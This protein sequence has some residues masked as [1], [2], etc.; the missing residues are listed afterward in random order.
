[1]LR[2]AN[3]KRNTVV[4]TAKLSSFLAIINSWSRV[5]HMAF[6]AKCQSNYDILLASLRTHITFN[7]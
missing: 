6:I 5:F 1:M 3:D 4:S 7:I 2:S